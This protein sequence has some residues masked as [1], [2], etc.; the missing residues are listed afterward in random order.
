VRRFGTL[1]PDGATLGSAQRQRVDFPEPAL[2]RRLPT[3]GCAELIT[4]Y[5]P[6]QSGLVEQFLRS[7]KEECLWQHRE[8]GEET[9][10]GIGTYHLQGI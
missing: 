7:V 3:T 9:E 10:I 4:P 1:R 2:S 6:E 8:K 5:T